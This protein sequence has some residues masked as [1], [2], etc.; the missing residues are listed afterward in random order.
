[1]DE[2]ACR[3]KKAL[4]E[5]VGEE[6][7]EPADGEKPEGNPSPQRKRP[8]RKQIKHAAKE[9]AERPVFRRR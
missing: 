7:R 3:P 1:M 9:V 5:R 6:P 8:S 2:R 4:Q